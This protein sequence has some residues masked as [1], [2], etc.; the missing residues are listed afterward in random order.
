M[1]R[2]E[3]AMRRK[4]DAMRRKEDARAGI[5]SERRNR[6]AAPTSRSDSAPA[7]QPSAF[8]RRS[9]SPPPRAGIGGHTSPI[10]L[11]RHP[12][13]P[14]SPPPRAGS[15]IHPA[16]KPTAVRR[17]A[18]TRTRIR[19]NV[20][21]AGVVRF[22]GRDASDGRCDASDGGC[23]ASEGG[24]DAPEGGCDASKE[25]AMRRKEDARAGIDSERRN[26]RAAP[27][28]RLGFRPCTAAIRVSSTKHHRRPRAPNRRTHLPDRATTAPSRARQSAAARR[29]P[30][31]SCLEADC[32]ASAD[33]AT[34]AHPVERGGGG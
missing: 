8:L 11:P 15:R 12:P 20:A 30:H 23:D 26:R 5:D 3:D 17:P 32:R 7:R 2:K 24:C 18:M 19:W 31:P 33:H 27:T 29:Q 34:D 25:D 9:T 28:S 6:R 16:R 13:A 4:E 10:A 22:G 1:R 14:G 21:G